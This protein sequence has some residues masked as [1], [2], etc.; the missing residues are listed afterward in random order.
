MR[1]TEQITWRRLGLALTWLLFL[2]SLGPLGAVVSCGATDASSPEGQSCRTPFDCPDPT[3]CACE[4][5]ADDPEDRVCVCQSLEDVLDGDPGVGDA[6]GEEESSIEVGDGDLSPDDSS[7]TEAE[8]GGG[9]EI[10]GETDPVE[11]IEIV[12]PACEPPYAAYLCPCSGDQDCLTERCVKSDAGKRCST[13]CELTTD[14]EAVDWVC[15]VAFDTCPDCETDCVW[16]H[17]A[18]CRPCMG[19]LDCRTNNYEIE[20]VCL[21]SGDEGS[22]C[23]SLCDADSGCPQG[24]RCEEVTLPSGITDSYCRYD[25]GICPCNE[26]AIAAEATTACLV[27]NE[28]G[29]CPGEATCTAD[30]LSACE[31]ES[32]SKEK[33]NSIDDDC[34]G[35]TDNEF[36]GNLCKTENDIGLCWGTEI[37]VEGEIL[38][39][40]L[41][42]E[43]EICDGIDNDCDGYTDK[44]FED[45]DL[46]GTPNC[47][48][49]DDDDDGVLDD[50]DSSG[51]VYDSPCVEGAT[52]G[53][54]DN[55]RLVD[56][57]LQ[58]D[59]DAD[60]VG[61]VCDCDADDDGEDAIRCDGTDC[62]DLN[63]L[64]NQGIAEVQ[65]TDGDCYYC[66]GKDDD[67]DGQTDEECFDLDSDGIPDCLDPDDD[68][69]DTPDISDNC[70][71]VWNPI[72]LDTDD[73]GLGDACD[74]D[75]DGDGVSYLDGDCDDLDIEVYPGAAE[76]CDGDDDN[77]DDVPDDGFPNMDN[78]D[79]ADCIDPDIDGDGV[80]ED[81]D[82]SGIVGD[83]LCPHLQREGCDDNCPT[84]T[85]FTQSD[86]DGDL[87]G[88]PCDPDMDADGSPNYDDNCP[89]VANGGQEDLDGDQTGDACDEDL[90]GDGKNNES[91]NCPDVPNMT[92]LDTDD[93]GAGDDCDDDDDGDGIP[94]DGDGSGVVGDQRC[95]PGEVAACD[96]NCPIHA[97]ADQADNELDGKG[98]ACD[99]D[100]DNDGIGEDGSGSGVVGDLPCTGGEVSACDDNCPWEA[101]P[102]QEDG[103]GDGIGDACDE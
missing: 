58:E 14:C 68:G 97:N 81:G 91:D 84:M 21:E 42:P 60:A 37:C 9:S 11:I 78:D 61:D 95:A 67:C 28:W 23:A 29:A 77:C 69:D 98:D 65:L 93:D 3:S 90:D 17:A 59:L 7:A 6:Q 54:D 16:Q 86:I 13:T 62:D 49:E 46:D 74:E 32:A 52:T 103:D 25:E 53:C 15:S 19:D 48:D 83:A 51:A 10:D 2:G 26:E 12:D 80:E 57:P 38:C 41:T 5:R 47:V 85:N 76:V 45:F 33:C 43:T 56:N 64:S 35:F 73:D 82:G 1:T 55:C 66:N 79:L 34:D 44:G 89:A 96:D 88:D 75:K 4:A 30:G 39:D 87:L 92:Q 100:D 22:F 40:A 20:A 102:G 99:L 94:E 31:G 70:V 63:P 50:G 36:A 18:L 71:M 72:Q 8:D 101:N 27:R 24:Y